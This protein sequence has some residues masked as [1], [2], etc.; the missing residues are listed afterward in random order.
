MLVEA[1]TLTT[2][3]QAIATKV[4]CTLVEVVKAYSPLEGAET[5][6]KSRVKDL[7]LAHL[8][9][10]EI[11]AGPAPAPLARAESHYRYQIML[12]TQQMTRL[13]RHLAQLTIRFKLPDE[14]S[15]TIDIDPTN[16]A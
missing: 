4:V 12:R 3:L 10:T 16:L 5:P 7:G 1:P 9:V 6:V 13:S 8:I 15:L 2:G 11:V 14:V